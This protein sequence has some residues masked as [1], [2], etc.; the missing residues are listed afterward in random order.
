ME[1]RIMNEIKLMVMKYP[2]EEI[3]YK[4]K[5]GEQTIKFQ[6]ELVCTHFFST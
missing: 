1:K 4:Y 3:N 2:D 5:L 6:I